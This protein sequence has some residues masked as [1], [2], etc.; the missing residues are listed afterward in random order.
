MPAITFGRRIFRLE[1]VPSTQD[2]IEEQFQLGV[3]EGTVAV[4]L[5]QTAGRGRIGRVWYSPAGKGL[6]ASVLLDPEGPPDNLTWVPLWAGVAVK[7]S[8]ERILERNSEFNPDDLL[9]KWP[10]DVML[11]DRKLGGI[12]AETAR[13]PNGRQAVILGAGI[14]L[15]QCEEVFPPHLQGKSISLM[16]AYGES[17]SPDEM[18]ESLLDSF[19]DQ[20]HLLKP[21]DIQS[22]KQSWIDAAWNLN[23]RLKV[24]SGDK[25][26]EGVFTGL[27]THGEMCLQ[28]EGMD[29]IYLSSADDIQQIEAL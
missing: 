6:W 3:E 11:N 22:I 24:S 7:R 20:Y 1:S 29:P 26:Y 12:L 23:R 25:S 14:N 9:L 15:L 28:S 8:I 21:V 27:G 19:Q 17:C 13:D 18:L 4:A 16:G 5:E 10:N 2:F